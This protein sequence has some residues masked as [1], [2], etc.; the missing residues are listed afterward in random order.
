M[1]SRAGLEKLLPKPKNDGLTYSL[2][3]TIL[4][5]AVGILLVHFSAFWLQVCGAAII[6][7]TMGYAFGIGACWA[8]AKRRSIH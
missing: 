2:S 7:F 5:L 1:L 3:I 4:G 8:W 6:F